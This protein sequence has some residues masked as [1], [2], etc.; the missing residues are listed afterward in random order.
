M[1]GNIFNRGHI[2][3][4]PSFEEAVPTHTYVHS[5]NSCSCI[6]KDALSPS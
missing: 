6:N 3:L 5:E 2:L 4:K 1:M